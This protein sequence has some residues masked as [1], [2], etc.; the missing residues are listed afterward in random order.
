MKKKKASFILCAGEKR[1]TRTGSE[2]LRSWGT[3]KNWFLARE[4]H[5]GKIFFCLQGRS[6]DVWERTQAHWLQE[7]RDELSQT[8]GK[9]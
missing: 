4:R 3:L 9:L 7:Q 6:F 5:R 1:V 8:G 2:G